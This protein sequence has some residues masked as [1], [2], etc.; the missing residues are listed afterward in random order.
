MGAAA[1]VLRRGTRGLQITA[2]VSEFPLLD[3]ERE[4]EEEAGGQGRGVVALVL[5]RVPFIHRS[6]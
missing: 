1:A 5:P 2:L 6:A 4:D 3:L